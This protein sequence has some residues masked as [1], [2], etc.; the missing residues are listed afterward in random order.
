MKCDCRVEIDMDPPRR[1]ATNNASVRIIHCPMHAAAGD[2]LAALEAIMQM[3]ATSPLAAC[4][5]QGPP[6]KKWMR[7][8]AP[9]LEA[10]YNA[11]REAQAIAK[12]VLDA[13]RGGA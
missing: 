11:I 12:P 2:M 1:V 7:E 8:V 6:P 3:Q 5:N 10:R 13:A 4:A 9:A